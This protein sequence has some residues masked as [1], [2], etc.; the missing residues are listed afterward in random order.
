MINRLDKLGEIITRGEPAEVLY[1][2]GQ[3]EERTELLVTYSDGK[4]RITDRIASSPLIQLSI[5]KD[6]ILMD[7]TDSDENADAYSYKNLRPDGAIFKQP[8]HPPYE[9][10]DL[11]IS[12][13][14]GKRKLAISQFLRS[15]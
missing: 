12:L 2:L 3:G 14:E 11:V 10:G 7:I 1:D 5:D 4:S 13:D 6:G 9:L 15:E 8:T